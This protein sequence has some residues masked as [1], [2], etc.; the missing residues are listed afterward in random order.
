MNKIN[1]TLA[2]PVK[3]QYMRKK[4]IDAAKREILPDFAELYRFKDL[5]LTLAWRDFRVRYAQTTIGFLWAFLQPVVSIALLSFIF[6]GIVGVETG[7][8]PILFTAVGFSLWSYFAFVMTNAGESIIA[9]Q[10]MI[11]KVYFPKLIIPL[12]KAI[13]GFIEFAI[14]LLII[15]ALMIFYKIAP[16]S[17]AWLGIVFI[18]IG[19]IAALSVG[20]WLSALTIR[21]RDF[22]HVVPFMVQIGYFIS[23]IGYPMEMVYA[24]FPPW[25]IDVYYLNPMAGVIQGFRW[26]ILGGEAPGDQMYISFA[27]VLVL[28]ITGMLYFKRVEDKMADLV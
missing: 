6:G 27:V 5:F 17:N 3:S 16:S 12:S 15:A 22:K 19:I 1:V 2:Q 13:V 18:F 7:Y 8:P 9:S 21:Y 26:S 4:V 14:T 28:F 24:K 25:L 10:N 23:P 11:K 20:I